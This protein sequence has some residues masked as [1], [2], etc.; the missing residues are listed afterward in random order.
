M[1]EFDRQLKQ[2]LLD[3]AVLY[4]GLENLTLVESFKRIVQ[5]LFESGKNQLSRSSLRL[6]RLLQVAHRRESFVL[7]VEVA[8][9]H[10]PWDAGG[11]VVGWFRSVSGIADAGDPCTS[12]KIVFFAVAPDPLLKHIVAS[13]CEI[14]RD[15]EFR[16]EFNNAATGQ[17]FRLA[18][19]TSFERQIVRTAN[20]LGL[21]ES[22]AKAVLGLHHLENPEELYIDYLFVANRRGLHARFSAKVVRCVESYDCNTVVFSVRGESVGGTSIMGLMMLD[23]G[24]GHFVE[25]VIHGRQAKELGAGLNRLFAEEAVLDSLQ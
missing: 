3:D 7:D 12:V 20:P 8:I 21:L 17:A 1:D 5:I 25:V 6:L 16:R 11:P 2:L 13:A 23:L 15:E 22:R 19:A 24:P 4:S 9:P 18:L 10:V 14:L